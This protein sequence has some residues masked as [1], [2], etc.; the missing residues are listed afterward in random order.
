MDLDDNTKKHAIPRDVLCIIMQCGNCPAL[1][2][3]NLP[4]LIQTT[5]SNQRKIFR[6][7]SKLVGQYISELRA[8]TLSVVDFMSDAA[9]QVILNQAQ[10]HGY[11]GQRTL[12]I[13]TPSLFLYHHHYQGLWKLKRVNNV[14]ELL[15]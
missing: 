13:M 5:Y 14:D 12:G 3:V 1:T 15:V 4:G 7:L 2:L 9:Y 8:I 10:E 6:S 11:Q